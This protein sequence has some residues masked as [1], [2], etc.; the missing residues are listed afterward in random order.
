MKHKATH[1]K[2][3]RRSAIGLVLALA[4]FAFFNLGE[5]FLNYDDF[6]LTKEQV[7]NGETTIFGNVLFELGSFQFTF[8][9][10]LSLAI[11]SL[12][13]FVGYR[14]IYVKENTSE[15]MIAVDTEM[16]KVA[17]PIDV[18]ANDFWD[19]TQQLRTSSSVV[20]VVILFLGVVLASY[21]WIFREAFT[22]IF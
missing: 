14:Y 1:G 21:D 19:K 6:G 9:H 20:F 5:F 12:I 7:N 10:V 22:R 4:V 17:W 3:A 15:F 11:G 8:S 13:A 18:E 2:I 16:K